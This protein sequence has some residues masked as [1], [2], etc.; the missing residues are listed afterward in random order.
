MKLPK[1]EGNIWIGTERVDLDALEGKVVLV[2]FWTYSCINCRRTIPH[3]R[4]WYKKYKDEGLVLIGIHSPEFEFEKDPV[5]VEK[6]MRELGV[7]WPVVLDNE[8][9]NWNNFDNHYWP[10][11][12]LADTKGDIA[13]THFGEG[14]YE[15]TEEKMRGLLGVEKEKRKSKEKA[16]H[17]HGSVCFLATPETYCGYMRGK[18]GNELGYTEGIEDD[19]KKPTAQ[20]EGEIVLDGKFLAEDEYVESREDGATLSLSFTGTEVNL[21]MAPALRES[22]VEILLNGEPIPE[23]V[24]GT[25][26]GANDEII[27]ERSDMFNLIKSKEGTHGTLGIRAVSGNFRAYAFTFSGC[28]DYGP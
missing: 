15:E 28:S 11:K 19:Y 4:E 20:S 6:A 13:Y 1:I 2:D 22:V 3:L 8:Y 26:V 24:R 16:G 7:I 25:D 9:K 23:N 21:V 10:A 27:V 14:S 18:T 17:T 5:N 12:F